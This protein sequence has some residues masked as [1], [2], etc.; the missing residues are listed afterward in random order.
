MQ[1]LALALHTA[2][3]RHA[4]LVEVQQKSSLAQVAAR[5]VLPLIHD[6]CIGGTVL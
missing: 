6:D 4:T 5:A 3:A 2:P 1:V